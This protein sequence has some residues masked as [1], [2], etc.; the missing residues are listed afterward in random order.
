MVPVEGTP[1]RTQMMDDSPDMT[2]VQARASASAQMLDAAF[3]ALE[4]PTERVIVPA[5]RRLKLRHLR[6]DWA[7]IRVLAA[8]DFKLKYQQSVLGPIWLIVQPLALLAA[9]LVAFRGLGNVQVN[10]E[11]Y[12]V[13]TLAG[14]SAWSFF[15]ASMTIG[16][17]SVITNF[18]YVRFT[19][20]PRT[21]FPLA[22]TLASLPSFGVVA[23]AAVVGSAATGHLTARVLLLPLALVWL[24][25]LT[26]AV[27]GITS[28]LAVR[29]RDVISALPLVLQVGVFLAPVG[30]SLASLS[31]TIRHLVELNPLTGVIETLRWIILGGYDPLLAPILIAA[32]L[33]VV[34]AIAGWRIFT[35]LE[36]T[37]AD[38]I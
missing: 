2:R 1:F 3:P 38:E 9:F 18:Q 20:C 27:I 28:S 13:F 35:R 30:Y 12:V 34:L 6:R 16:T 15:Q 4:D 23:L 36:T 8:R 31:P 25:L 17:A 11:P 19:P 37:M 7:V 22:A 21:A 32:V 10:N 5:R 26:A 29:Y 33:T 24:L 14:L